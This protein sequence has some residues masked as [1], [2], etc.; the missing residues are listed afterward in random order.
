MPSEV[1]SEGKK[2]KSP[3]LRDSTRRGKREWNGIP[4]E[5]SNYGLIHYLKSDRIPAMSRLLFVFLLGASFFA[6]F[7]K[8]FAEERVFTNREG[9]KI[10]ATIETVRAGEVY[11]SVSGNRFQI[12]FASLSDGDQQFLKEWV[13]TNHEYRFD[14]RV[15][16]VEDV[17]ARSTERAGDSKTAK[18]LWNYEVQIRNLSGLAAKDLRIEYRVFERFTSGSDMA[19]GKAQQDETGKM[20]PGAITVT[21]IANTGST[22]FST[23]NFPTEKKTWKTSTSVRNTDGTYYDVYNNHE[24]SNELD[25]VWIRVYIGQRLIAEH[26]SEGKMIKKMSWDGDLLTPP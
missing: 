15:R 20:H 13:K 16:P 9:K 4:E 1:R 14:F 8:G 2:A 5:V 21:E 19:R 18:S 25:G 22:S 26:K 7:V 11:L 24:T 23:E 6:N 10:T 17:A 12:P 3:P